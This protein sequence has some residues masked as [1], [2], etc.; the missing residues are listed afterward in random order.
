VQDQTLGHG[1]AIGAT[2]VEN[3]HKHGKPSGPLHKGCDLRFAAFT[4]NQIAF[5]ETGTAQSSAR[6]AV[7]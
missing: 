7:S 3:P 4:D 2:I 1:D 6:R 5:P